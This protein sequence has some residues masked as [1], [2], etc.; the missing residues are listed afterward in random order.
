MTRLSMK[1]NRKLY[2]SPIIADLNTTDITAHRTE[3]SKGLSN[4]LMCDDD[5]MSQGEQ[6]FEYRYIPEVQMKIE[7]SRV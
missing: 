2:F 3:L 1:E 7:L 5:P 4:S 6:K